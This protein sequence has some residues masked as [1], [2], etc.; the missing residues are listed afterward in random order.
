MLRTPR[1]LAHV[2]VREIQAEGSWLCVHI[3]RALAHAGGEREQ[4]EGMI[5]EAP[6]RKDRGESS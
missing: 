6:M 2:A 1:A 3:P 5:E 4:A